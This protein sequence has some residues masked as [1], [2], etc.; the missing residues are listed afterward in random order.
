M[1]LNIRI[2]QRCFYTIPVMYCDYHTYKDI[3]AAAQGTRETLLEHLSRYTNLVFNYGGNR[4][5]RTVNSL[6]RIKTA[7]SST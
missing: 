3:C 6:R 2:A 7:L 1:R 4:R 5:G